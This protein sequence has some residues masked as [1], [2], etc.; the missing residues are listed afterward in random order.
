VLANFAEIKQI[1]LDGG[2]VKVLMPV[3]YVTDTPLL[4]A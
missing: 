4:V 3:F 1:L 2:E